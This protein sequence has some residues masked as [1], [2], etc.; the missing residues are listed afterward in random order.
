MNDDSE[1]D[2][3]RLMNSTQRYILSAAENLLIELACEPDL[4]EDEI[5]DKTTIIGRLA[6]DQE[7]KQYLIEMLQA[8]EEDVEDSQVYKEILDVLS[9]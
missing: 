1:P 9:E 6:T 3:T 5:R 4:T 8:R 7:Q 2:E